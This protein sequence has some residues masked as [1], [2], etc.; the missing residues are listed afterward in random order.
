MIGTRL[1]GRYEVL[2]ELGQG[3]MGVVYRARDEVL[4]RE[5][6]V[7]VIAAVGAIS[8]EAERR[9]RSEAQ[10]IAQLDHPSIITI[11]DFGRDQ[12]A[13]FYV[14][15]VVE[16][17]SLLA[18]IDEGLDLGAVLDI[19]VAVADALAYT[20][21]RGI[22]HR[23]VKPAN[24]LVARDEG[25]PPRV[26]VMD[27]GLARS[28]GD[29]P[30]TRTGVLVG[31]VAY[32]SPEIV[33][34]RV[35]DAA[36]DIYALGNALYEA[37]VGE[38]P[39]V[40]E[41]PGLLYRISHEFPERPSERGVLVDSDL[42]ALV[43]SCLAKNPAERPPSMAVLARALRQIRA[44]AARDSPTH[45]ELVAAAP[46]RGLAP[47]IGRQTELAELQQRLA[48]AV[49]GE[50]Q[51]VVVGGDAGVGKTRLLAELEP[52]AVARGLVVLHGQLAEQDGHF[53]HYGLCEVLL[54][55]FRQRE[56]S[57][58]PV[59]DLGDL[60]PDLVAIF[61][62]LGEVLAVRAALGAP[63][64]AGGR[65]GD[66]RSQL[67]ETLARVFVRLAA[68]GPL[69][70]FLED[71]HAASASLEALQY[72]VRR[73][74]AAPTLVVATYRTTEVDRHHPIHR[75]MDELRGARRFAGITLGPLS[76]SEHRILLTSLL[77]EVPVSELVAA[78]LYDTTEGNPFFTG[79][80]VRSLLSGEA[81]AEGADTWLLL[82]PSR[83]SSALP[84]TIQQAI[85]RRTARLPEALREVLACA[86][87]IGRTFD[88][89]DLEHLA[90]ETEDLD[91]AI[92]RLVQEG[93]L[94]EERSARGDRLS[95]ASGVAREVLYS[96]VPRRRRRGLHRRY[97]AYL[98][99]R[100]A[101]RES[102][103]YAQLLYHYSEGDMPAPS[104]QY[105][106]RAARQALESYNPDEAIR[107][108]RTALGFL[109]EEWE[110]DPAALGEV[111]ELLAAAYRM[112]GDLDGALREVEAAIAA[113]RRHAHPADEVRCLLLAARTAWQ[114]RRTDDTR[115]WVDLGVAAARAAAQHEVLGQLLALAATLAN[116]RGESDLAAEYLREAELQGRAERPTEGPRPD[117][118]G[119][120]VVA[121]IAPLHAAEP[122]FSQTHEDVE[123]LPNVF[124]TLLVASEDGHLLPCLAERWEP[125]RGGQT[126][127]LSL[128]PG[129]RFHDGHPF[130]ASDVVVAWTRV[131]LRRAGELPAA[132]A[133][134]E[135][136]AEVRRGEASEVR[137]LRVLGEHRLEID[138]TQPLAIYPAFL[139][140]P[141]TA[142]ARV[143][144]EGHAC[145]TGPFR[146]TSIGPR[147][148]LLGRH[149][150]HWRAPSYLDALEFRVVEDAAAMAQ[151]LRARELD[152]IGAVAPEEFGGQGQGL[153]A[154]VV[155]VTA[156]IT[157]FTVFNAL[158]GPSARHLEVR[159]ALADVVP[160]QELVWQALGRFAVP[161]SGLVPPGILGH[162]P[163]R[164]R[165]PLAPDDARRI[166]DAA[167]VVSVRV[168]AFPVL[169][170]R[171]RPLVDALVEQWRA[172]GLA[173]ELVRLDMERFIASG[174]LPADIDVVLLRWG[175]D[176]DDPDDFTYG[177]FHSAS[178]HWRAFFS[179]PEADRLLERGRAEVEPAVRERYYREF[180][181][182]L[183]REG[184]VLPLFY[185]V[186]HRVAGPR[187]AGLRL[188]PSP[189]FA[190]YEDLSRS[191]PQRR[192]TDTQVSG[193]IRVPIRG[194]VMTLDPTLGGFAEYH[195][196]LPSIF[197]SLT[198]RTG[199]AQIVPCLA[200]SVEAVSGGTAYRFKLRRDIT[201]HDGH[202]LGARD[203][204]YSF[205]RMLR[206]ADAPDRWLFAPI[207]G[208]HAMLTGVASE[209]AGFQIH[210]SHE[211][212][213]ELVR[214][215]VYFPGLLSH[216]I[217]AVVPEG[218]DQRGDRWFENPVG[219]GPFR[220]VT[221]DPG[222]RLQLE[223]HGG[224]WRPGYPRCRE[225]VFHFG[226]PAAEIRSGFEAGR[227][228]IAGELLPEDV[229]ALRR[230]PRHVSGYRE[231]PAFATYFLV[232]NTHRG[233]LTDP[234]LRRLV[235]QAIDRVRLARQT[236]GR[237]AK[238]AHGLI[239][240]GLLGHKSELLTPARAADTPPT[241]VQ[242]VTLSALV[243]LVFLG[244]HKAYLRRLTEALAAVGV[245]LQIVDNLRDVS[246]AGAHVDFDLALTR[247]Y[248]DYPDPHSFAGL[249]HSREGRFGGLC[250]SERCDR[251]L[252]K[253]QATVDPQVRHALYR[254]IEDLVEQEASV[255]PLFY[256][257]T[258]R[259]GRPEVVGLEVSHGGPMVAYEELSLRDE[260]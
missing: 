177:H 24:I 101:G 115:R 80:V 123:V 174:E 116:L 240:P 74:A 205:E 185:A 248:A 88:A 170:E 206:R 189:P 249:L 38:P 73:L 183:Q 219:T 141:T 89:R 260:A 176:Y 169:L 223:R 50:G 247:W 126:F 166:L 87:V 63:A 225:L 227:F 243:N 90:R 213:I 139:T 207:V 143:A 211:F 61:P 37:I 131:V 10:T 17:K 199:A 254:Q 144:G 34:G 9:F 11:Y 106:L 81:G 184:A 150:G 236:I 39:F 173:V 113:Y 114:A 59:P 159:R 168:L 121:L 198:R 78:R 171:Y 165:R 3:G 255:I 27:F 26:T 28:A 134:V 91:D 110:G 229:E 96:Q 94:V 163:G 57:G 132:L 42:E 76:R 226:V 56:A 202:R 85:D 75:M 149:E 32:L 194:Q 192:R 41:A 53:P 48:R 182:L 20:H 246:E 72:I 155:E 128:R 130:T 138:L 216:S 103:V 49:A 12:G 8:D 98:E 180:E 196:V 19:G 244:E 71:L 31:T 5:V 112:I 52:L 67:F 137:G 151:G 122:A 83:L 47:L 222:R 237:L 178:G 191:A 197:E 124:E 204:R 92:D 105:G 164:R 250:G 214:P 256:P 195:E 251:L 97:A 253:A 208:A 51:F 86:A 153:G 104:V 224:Y 187:V 2:S 140:N 125:R 62:T 60:A 84:A 77:G 1:A 152:I 235:A 64:P 133:V 119:R 40:G 68:V 154:A 29:D 95:F 45:H 188:R 162:D 117:R 15:P 212:T 241:T 242:E 13:L 18:W 100:Y 259:F 239:P 93:L 200:E 210:G 108:A 146:L 7:K 257:Q 4:G 129:V 203:V 127:A 33:A 147:A 82:S 179:S 102:R 221:F 43:M 22:V 118:G 190:N 238:P 54:D 14:M 232:L 107:A 23:D 220:V 181:D 161:A 46:R 44:R 156:K 109:D 233:P 136:A 66:G 36:S 65:A 186:D 193:V 142:I 258:Y 135:G 145:G 69:A 209:L 175:A 160:L 55:Y 35:A 157:F 58:E 228:T 111:R 120:L 218:A 6:A 99:A 252:E 234:G 172:L 158:G 25:G 215:L 16:G 245:R 167:G 70:L 230:D 231:T 217:C 148:A 201:F 30:L 79:E 21:A